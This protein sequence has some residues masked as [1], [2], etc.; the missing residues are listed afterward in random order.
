MSNALAVAAVTTTLR[1]LLTNALSG[2]VSV[3]AKPLDEARQTAIDQVNLFLYQVSPNA[4]LRNTPMPGQTKPGESGQPP[5]A[6]TLYYLVTAYGQNNEDGAAHRLLGQVMGALHDHPLLHPDE[7]RNATLASLPDSDLHAQVERV[8]ITPHTISLEDISKLWAT[9]QTQFR[10]SAAYQVS[11]VLIEST[12][13]A[14]T[15]LP[16]LGRGAQ[17]DAGVATQ[18]DV[19]NPFPTLLSAETPDPQFG[20]LLGQTLTLRG[21]NLAGAPAAVRLTHQVLDL[22]RVLTTLITHT[23]DEVSV[24]VPNQPAD[25]PAGFWTAAVEVTRPGET[26][27]RTTNRQGFVLAPEATNLPA[28][29]PRNVQGLAT[30]TINCRPEVRPTQRA[31]LLLGSR[32]I[33]AE[34]HPA[35]TATLTFRVTNPT[36]AA[37]PAP[38]EHFAR[39]RVDGVDSILVDR[40]GGVPVFNAN[41]KVTI[42]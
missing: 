10:I 9:F 27:S 30:V 34:A 22:E 21:Q 28:S 7:I 24:A 5:L 31:A 2:V 42:T 25:F 18:P 8:R 40:T 3:T 17:D 1:S 39:L 32:E 11:V 38:V 15:P 33:P 36:P 29:F 19:T 6:L 23:D 14:R 20:A 37:S 16:A 35:Q 41:Q 12:R 4:A 13:P 26:F